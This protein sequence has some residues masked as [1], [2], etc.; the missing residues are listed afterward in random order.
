MGGDT[1]R[2]A[3]GGGGGGVGTRSADAYRGQME[4]VRLGPLSGGLVKIP[5]EHEMLQGLCS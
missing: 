4:W 1:I 5:R 2:R 3:A